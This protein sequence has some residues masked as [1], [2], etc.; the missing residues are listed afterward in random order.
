MPVSWYFC[1]S[2]LLWYPLMGVCVIT[3]MRCCKLDEHRGM[4]AYACRC[5]LTSPQENWGCFAVLSL[6]KACAREAFLRSLCSL[7]L[8]GLVLVALH[9]LDPTT[10]TGLCMFPRGPCCKVFPHVASLQA[11]VSHA[12]S[13]SA[14]LFGHSPRSV[15]RAALIVAVEGCCRSSAWNT[16]ATLCF[17]QHCRP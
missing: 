2:S 15:G 7:L 6:S 1:A 10:H 5:L 16:T 13:R 12:L 4:H 8:P 14:V 11:L 3:V 17:S 9:C